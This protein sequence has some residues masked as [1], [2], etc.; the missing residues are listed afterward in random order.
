VQQA[1]GTRALRDA[2]GT[3]VPLR[4]YTRIASGTLVSDR[5][6]LDLCE[7]AR[8]VAFTRYAKNTPQGYRYQG[9]PTIGAHEDV[10]R[11]LALQPELI[12]VS[13]LVDPNFVARLRERGVQV[14][15]LGP[16][17]G[18]ASLLHSI[19][20]I[21]WLTGAPERA[22]RYARTLE[23]RLSSLAPRADGPRTLYL[24]RYG[25]KLFA[26]GSA[27]SYH[28][29]IQYA[30]L[31]DAASDYV[32][33]PELTAEGVL[34]IDPEVLLTRT[35]MSPSLCRH[36]GLALIRPCQPGGRIIEL[37]GALLDDPGPTML[38]AAEALRRAYVGAH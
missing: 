38:E 25:D 1:D 2:R 30:G 22:E 36:P 23:A 31:R 19:R 12:I 24:A 37:D 20:A 28:D 16:M 35:G 21:G 3:L 8:I 27:T 26:A 34:A 13:D 9:K 29:V 32:G 18:L 14:F 17:S 33:W 15:D 6:L 11:V 5:V 7:P 4:P 10:E